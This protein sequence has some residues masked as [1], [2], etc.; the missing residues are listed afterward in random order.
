VHDPELLFLDEPTNGLDPRGRE[1]ML[2]LILEIPK[3]RGATLLVSTHILA[4]VER[5]CESALVLNQGAIAYH[6]TLDELR[7][8]GDQGLEVRVKKGAAELLEGLAAKGCKVRLD[9]DAV[10]VDELPAGAGTD[11]VLGEARARGLQIRHL[12]MR[13]LTLEDAFLRTVKDDAAKHAAG[14]SP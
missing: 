10:V 11:L 13:K 8:K 5:V 14:G 9:G 7:G 1:E 6:G 3:R 2:A 4:D 12:A